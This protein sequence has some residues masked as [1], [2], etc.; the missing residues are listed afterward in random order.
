MVT[1]TLEERGKIYGKY[2]DGVKARAEILGILAIHHYLKNG[3]EMTPR[4]MV[5]MGDLV[6]KLVR[7][8]SDPKHTDNFHD[9]AGYATLIEEEY[10]ELNP[11]GAGQFSQKNYE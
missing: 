2:G 7:A 8:A 9:L 4:L 5:M 1:E 3:T 6:M 11:K 10:N